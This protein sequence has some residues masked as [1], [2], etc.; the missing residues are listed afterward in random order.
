MSGLKGISIVAKNVND[1]IK[2][3]SAARHKKVDARATQLIAEEMTLLKIRRAP[4]KGG[5]ER[6]TRGVREN[7]DRP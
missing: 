1:I 3:L 2:R 4:K 5:S 7:N 6:L